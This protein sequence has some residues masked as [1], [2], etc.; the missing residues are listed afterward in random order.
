MCFFSVWPPTTTFS[1]CPG[2]G[3]SGTAAATTRD[4]SWSG[5]DDRQHV[6]TVDRESTPSWRDDS[7]ANVDLARHRRIRVFSGQA[8]CL[9]TWSITAGSSGSA[10]CSATKYRTVPPGGHRVPTDAFQQP[11]H[12][13]RRGRL[14]HARPAANGCSAADPD[15]NVIEVLRRVHDQESPGELAGS[16]AVA[17]T[18]WCVASNQRR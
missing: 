6:P 14:R 5:C 9:T 16:S 3:R 17:T 13:V 1:C 10:W 8:Q 15:A 4:R 2:C 12:P 7:P 11:L 18:R